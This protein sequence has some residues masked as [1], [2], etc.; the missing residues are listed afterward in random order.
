MRAHLCLQLG[1]LLL[2]CL[3]LLRQARHLAA[4][5]HTLLLER[6]AELRALLQQGTQSRTAACSTA[7]MPV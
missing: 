4:A 2:R 1:R 5:V 7:L 6:G 3:S